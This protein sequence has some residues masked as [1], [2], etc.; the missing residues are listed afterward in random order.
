M[1]GVWDLSCLENNVSDSDGDGISG[2]RA[3][4]AWAG[5]LSALCRRVLGAGLD[6]RMQCSD[7]QRRPL[8]PRQVQ[9]ASLD[10]AVLVRIFE[11]KEAH[12]SDT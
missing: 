2:D 4:D 12:C 1:E 11:K 3:G 7:W 9:Y 8:H 5:G 6:K 10:A